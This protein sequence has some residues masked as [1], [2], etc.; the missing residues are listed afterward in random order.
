MNQVRSDVQSALN[1]ILPIAAGKAQALKSLLQGTESLGEKNPIHIALTSLRNV[2]F[3]HFA[4]IQNDTRLAVLTIYDGDF[5]AYITS[6]V[7]HVGDVFN[8]I[9]K[10]IEGGTAIIPVQAKRDAF[11]EF[12]RRYDVPSLGGL[13]SA[14]PNQRVFDILDAMESRA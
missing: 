1:L 14:Y 13:F 3:A 7:H 10:H 12:I 9:L 2:H 11:L 6:F 5:D 8:E 4:F